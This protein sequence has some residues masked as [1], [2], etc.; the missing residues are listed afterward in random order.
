MLPTCRAWTWSAGKGRTN[1]PHSIGLPH[2]FCNPERL[3]AAEGAEGTAFSQ[4][5]IPDE[6]PSLIRWWDTTNLILPVRLAVRDES[7]NC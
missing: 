7:R 1:S 4:S 2:P 3:G 6:N 5:I